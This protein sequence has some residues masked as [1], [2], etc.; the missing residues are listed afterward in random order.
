MSN[1]Q[2]NIQMTDPT[3]DGLQQNGF[4]LYGFKAVQGPPNGRPLVWF[5][6]H[7]FAEETVVQ[8][9]DN[10]EAYTSNPGQ[11][12]QQT[13][14]TAS[15][16]YDIEL[17]QMLNVSNPQGTG[18]V[19]EGPAP[20]AIAIYNQTN[21]PFICGVSQ[22]QGSGSYAPLCGFPLFGQSEDLMVPIELVFLMFSANPVNTG[23]VIEL[24]YNTGVLV[25]LTGS[26]QQTV[27]YDLNDGWTPQPG[28][29]VY[30]PNTNLVPLL[31]PVGVGLAQVGG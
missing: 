21:T 31:I 25:D 20:Q 28:V 23:T 17:G 9:T 18:S 12:A 27:A 5:T 26:P 19:L 2:I 6:T 1:Y 13:V 10:Y 29:K 7:L 22:K 3:V 8:W 16:A 11:L 24:S 15:A 30:P 4:K 14:V